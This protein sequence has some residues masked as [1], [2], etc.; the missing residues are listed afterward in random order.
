MSD[1]SRRWL[2]PLLLLLA[3]SLAL[4]VWLVTPGLTGGRF[5]DERYGVMN[6]RALLR[7]GELHPVKGFY[8]GLSY[9]PQAV[10]L[11]GAELLHRWTGRSVFAVFD[12][13]GG[14][15][16]TGY[17]LC[18]FLQA[19]AGTLSLYLTF[20]IGRR[21]FSPGVGL[22][23]ALLLAGVPWHLRQSVIFKP[24]IVLTAACLL[25]FELSLAAAD[26]Q[27]WRRF[28]KAGAAVGLA[29]AAKLSAG[30]IAVPLIVAALSGG[31]WRDRRS[32]GRLIAAGGVSIA[33][34]VLLTPFA[35]LD[36]DFY[37][38]Q[39]GNTVRSYAQ[40]AVSRGNSHLGTFWVGLGAPLSAGYHGPLLGS[41]ALLGL[42][43]WG[44]RA[45]WPRSRGAEA[46]PRSERLG[47]VMAVA[48]VLAFVLLYS[49]ATPF[50]KGNNW[51]PLA[52]F[53]SLAA[54]WV[55]VRLWQELS[56]RL[57]LLR[58][59]AAGV[60]AAGAVALLLAAPVTLFTYGAAVP[61]TH[62]LA[63]RSLLARLPAEPGRA[64]VFERGD[65]PPWSRPGRG[66]LLLQPVE[67]LD[68]LGP[69][70][71]ALADA[72]LFPAARLEDE[73]RPFYLGRLAADRSVTLR[74]APALFRARGPEVLVVLHAWSPVG[75]PIP[76]RLS[77]GP[78][79][80]RWE[81][82][83]PDGVQP[84]EIVSV[85]MVLRTGRSPA[86][87]RRILVAGQTVSWDVIGREGRRRCFFTQRFPAAAPIVL[88]LGHPLPAG[89]SI[90]G[91]LR[92]WMR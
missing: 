66:G 32:W 72:E 24:D 31:G 8:P 6:L 27:D 20:R 87:V 57:P 2:L 44:V 35:V 40:S 1:P 89:R 25:A 92:R 37:L 7:D 84:G 76:L 34:F 33:A 56:A 75:A 23:A 67:R 9:L 39:N 81:G 28:T 51:L 58:H 21:L 53:T 22:L 45:F 79:R 70:R 82:R 18:R 5:W 11:A 47:P 38:Q 74:F 65:A 77:P 10:P 50:P 64:V 3:W 17:F 91:Y 61:V 83:L 19:L 88:E 42:A 69:A 80:K 4:R 55:L 63:R 46:V 59:R 36:F 90:D 30:P 62:E 41:L 15:T 78:G 86:L 26:R 14:M 48:F 60:A 16:P 54:A 85:E 49:I 13:A 12:A 73:S 68:L 71:L 43:V 29:L 52:P